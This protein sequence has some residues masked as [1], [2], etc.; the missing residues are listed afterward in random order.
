[1]DCE[2]KL[3]AIR[4]VSEITGV[5]PVTLR[6]WQRR[7]N[8]IKPMRTE[9]GHRLYREEDIALIQSVQAWLDK[10]VSIGKVKALL[11]AD[12][13][14]EGTDLPVS[15]QLDEVASLTSALALLNKKKVESVINTVLKEY[16]LSVVMDQF[17]KPIQDSLS[18]VKRNQQVLQAAL[19]NG[20]LV[21]KLEAIVEAEN[22]AAHLGKC[23]YIN[24]DSN[25][26]VDSRVWAAKLS[27][28]GWNMTLLDGVDDIS[29]LTRAELENIGFSSIALYSPRPL[30]EQQLS[31]IEN[32]KSTFSGTLF[33]SDVLKVSEVS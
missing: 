14:N 6:A 1:M 29:G 3:Y 15:E 33:L 28:K 8:L 4:E 5:K 11:D 26:D 27:D 7:Y 31:S 30:T 24:F 13:L 25:R 9:K 2:K 17:V 20:L 16:P 10:G 21:S 18:L 22:K 32:V 23:L 12:V 19:F